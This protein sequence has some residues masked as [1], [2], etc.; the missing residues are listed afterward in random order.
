MRAGGKGATEDELI[1]G[2]HQLN[3]HEFEETPGGGEGQGSLGA[4]V[5]GVTKSQWNN[6]LRDGIEVQGT[7]ST[8]WGWVW[9]S[10]V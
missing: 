7:S 2:H 4:A 6:H 10:V 1:G 8:M 3:R 9:N 5:R